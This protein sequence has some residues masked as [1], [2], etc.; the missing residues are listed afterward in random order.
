MKDNWILCNFPE[1]P[2][3]KNPEKQIQS[4]RIWAKWEGGQRGSDDCT[5]KA[6]KPESNRSD[7]GD[8]GVTRVRTPEFFFLAKVKSKNEWKTKQVVFLELWITLDFNIEFKKV[9]KL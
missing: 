2:K 6:N 5:Q 8:S 9:A 1:I 4:L 7:V 3:C